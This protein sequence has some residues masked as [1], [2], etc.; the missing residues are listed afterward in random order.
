M[1]HVPGVRPIAFL[2][3][4][5]R[6]AVA[7]ATV[8]IEFRG[9]ELL[10]IANGP[11][12]AARGGMGRSRP[13]AG[14]AAH[15][16][17]RGLDSVPQSQRG[18]SR[19]VAAETTSDGAYRIERRVRHVLHTFMPW[20]RPHGLEGRVV[21]LA[22]LDVSFGSCLTDV[23]YGFRAGAKGPVTRATGR[24]DDQRLRVAGPGL[25]PKFVRMAGAAS[26][27]AHIPGLGGNGEQ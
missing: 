14:L 23:S 18:L 11:G 21:S 17:L 4:L 2:A 5:G 3:G 10:G 27:A 9:V 7:D 12:S 6:L 15:A 26:L 19:G 13:V 25:R 8:L 20:R 24:R 1:A 22:V 16:C